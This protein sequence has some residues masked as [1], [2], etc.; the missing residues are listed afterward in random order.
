MAEATW[1]YTGAWY[2]LTGSGAMT[3]GWFHLRRLLVLR[4]APAR[5]DHRLAATGLQLVLPER[6]RRNGH[7]LAAT[8]R[9]LV[10]P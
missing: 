1:I 10:L 7:R 5:D 4:G 3:T 6:L 9:Q 8:G 2:Y